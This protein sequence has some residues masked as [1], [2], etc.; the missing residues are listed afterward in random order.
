MEHIKETLEESVVRAMDGRDIGLFPFLPYIFQDVWELGAFPDTVI[1]LIR[2]HV[3][4]RSDIS[5][6]DLGCG[7]G[8]VSVKVAKEFGYKCLGI[9]AVREFIYE[10]KRKAEEY[11]VLDICEF[12]TGDIRE[13]AR[14]YMDFDVVMLGS[15]GPV[16]GDH[17][18]TLAALSG[19]IKRGGVIIIDDGYIEDG[20]N[21]THH[22]SQKKADVMRQIKEAGMVVVEEKF[23]DR[24]EITKFEKDIFS[25]LYQRCL[26]LSEQYPDKKDL[27]LEYV[28]EQKEEGGFLLNEFTCSTMVLRKIG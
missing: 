26:E 10:A 22:S 12:R 16:M 4:K 2:R 25:K 3:A 24:D 11:G 15:I 5:F 23:I 9:D 18:T 17:F 27:F 28:K 14:N 13:E 19:V 8:A 1:E 6:L 20:S 7:K 21:F